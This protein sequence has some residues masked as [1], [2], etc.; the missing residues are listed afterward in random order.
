MYWSTHQYIPWNNCCC[1]QD[2]AFSRHKGIPPFMSRVEDLTPK[3]LDW[4]PWSESEK[5]TRL[6][7]GCGEGSH[8]YQG[9]QSPDLMKHGGKAR[10]SCRQVRLSFRHEGLYGRKRGL[11]ESHWELIEQDLME[12]LPWGF[13]QEAACL[14][15]GE[16]RG[17]WWRHRC[18][19]LATAKRELCILNFWFALSPC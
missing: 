17:E 2:S 1:D 9:L 14:Q 5:S 11:K 19:I 15:Q 13:T 4:T 8:P 18:A 16:P 6:V 10:V 12:Q 3:Q 7:G